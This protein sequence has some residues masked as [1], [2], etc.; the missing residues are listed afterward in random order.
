MTKLFSL[1]NITLTYMFILYNKKYPHLSQTR[2]FNNEF[3]LIYEKII[4]P[5]SLFH[6]FFSFFLSIDKALGLHSIHQI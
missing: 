6:G 5:K 1:I 3:N 4:I 2:I